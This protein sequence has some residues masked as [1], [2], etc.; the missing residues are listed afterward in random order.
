MRRFHSCS[1]VQDG[2]AR[3][4]GPHP[5]SMEGLL[6]GLADN[7]Q[8]DFPVWAWMHLG[9]S[10]SDEID[11]LGNPAQQKFGSDRVSGGPH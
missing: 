3:G 11:D 10:L 6:N 2:F 1:L 9:N 5:Q 8:L 7:S 4:A